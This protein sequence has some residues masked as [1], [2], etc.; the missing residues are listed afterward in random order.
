MTFFS[1]GVETNLSL[2]EGSNF[3]LGSSVMIESESF[4]G[5]EIEVDRMR[6]EMK[7]LQVWWSI[8]L[9]FVWVVVEMD[10]VSGCGPRIAWF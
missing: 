3:L 8:D 6:P 1:G 10:S 5:R 9:V 4:L 2:C 7:L